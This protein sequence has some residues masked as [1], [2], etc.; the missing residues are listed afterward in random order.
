MYT[1]VNPFFAISRGRDVDSA[2]DPIVPSPVL[3]VPGGCDVDS[4]PDPTV[5]PPPQFPGDH[6][7]DSVISYQIQ[8]SV[9]VYTY[10]VHQSRDHCT[11]LTLGSTPQ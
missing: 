5:S 3:T 2:P 8:Y 1:Y 4:G 11:Y 6:D 10:S 7:V 9:H